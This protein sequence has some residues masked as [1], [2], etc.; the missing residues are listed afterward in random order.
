MMAVLGLAQNEVHEII[1]RTLLNNE[2]R[3]H[4]KF[5]EPHIRIEQEEPL[6]SRVGQPNGYRRARSITEYQS[7][8]ARRV[9]GQISTGNDPAK[10]NTENNVHDVTQILRHTG[11]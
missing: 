8:A 2:T 1:N 4:K 9:D 7:R 10:D 3:I 11:A 6:C 5:A